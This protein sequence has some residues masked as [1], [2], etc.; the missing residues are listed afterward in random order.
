MS[1]Q[2]V[3]PVI[4]TNLSA[5]TQKGI[6]RQIC[7]N[8][9]AEKSRVQKTKHLVQIYLFTLKTNN[10]YSYRNY[11]T[12]N[13]K[14][15]KKKYKLFGMSYLAISGKTGSEMITR[16]QHRTAPLANHKTSRRA[17][18]KYELCI[19]TESY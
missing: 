18:S 8:F 14:K 16:I 9:I 15:N 1:D 4:F 13:R 7:W 12:C 10:L 5:E 11:K 3:N 6:D 2:R 19:N 17:V